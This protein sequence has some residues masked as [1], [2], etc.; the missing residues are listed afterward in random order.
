MAENRIIASAVADNEL[1]QAFSDT[2]AERWDNWDLSP[3]MAYLVD[4]CTPTIL[5][6]LAEQFDVNGLQGFE[7]AE[8]EQQQRDL[9]K[10][11]IALHKFIGT[12]WAI[13]E[14][15][16]TVGYP[17][18]VLE[19]G[20]TET[21]GGPES[22]EDW[23]RFRVLV[24]A[25]FSRQITAEDA[26]KLRI[27]V[28]FYKNA[29]SHLVELGFYQSLA[30]KLFRTPQ[31]RED[32][33]V[34]FLSLNPN[35]VN[36]NPNGTRQTI[37]AFSNVPWV[38]DKRE[39]EWRDGTGGKLTLEFTGEAGH[40]EIVVTSDYYAR[41]EV[42]PERAYS[43]A[44]S[45]AY[46]FPEDSDNRVMDIKVHSENGRLLGVL[47]IIQRPGNNNAYGRAYSNAYNLFNH[48]PFIEI[49]VPIIQL[50]ADGEAVQVYVKTN[51][52]WK[53]E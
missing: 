42:P 40:S 2:V 18:I 28:E 25:D 11:S 26:R 45:A 46:R 49:D 37:A 22:P 15:C 12:P 8:N 19:E 47:R 9:I 44:Y 43:P 30:D 48:D 13:R 5:P 14:A 51:T 23:A 52:D 1:A 21:P 29:R 7:I 10:R 4:V 6:Y 33:D 34:E 20:V 50:P 38:I 32:L 31:Q 3:Y 41:P 24:E 35:P 17:V 36:L 39:Y 16:R 53:I 27:F